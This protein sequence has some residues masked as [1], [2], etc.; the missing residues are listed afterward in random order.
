MQTHAP[1]HVKILP[2]QALQGQAD[3]ANKS[4]K[5]SAKET[6]SGTIDADGH[7]LRIGG[8]LIVWG[9]RS[10]RDLQGEY[11]TPQTELA[12]E[13]FERR[14]V[15]YQHGLDD[16]L[17]ANPIGV[18]DQLR[19][20][21]TGVWA[22]AQ[23]DLRHRYADAVRRLIER[24][25][26]GW[27]SGSL[28]HLVE[29]ARDGRIVRW[30]LVEGSLTP[31]PAEPRRTDVQT[32]KS[33]YEVLGLDT[34]RLALPGLEHRPLHPLMHSPHPVQLPLPRKGTRP[35]PNPY[36]DSFDLLEHTPVND[37]TGRKRLPFSSSGA[38]DTQPLPAVNGS[39]GQISVG[40][41]FDRL[42]AVDLLHGYMLLR[43][44]KSFHGVSEQYANALAYK[45]RKTGLSSAIKTNEL[46][47]TM[48]TGFGDEWV[49]ELWSA[50][51]WEKARQDNVVLP[52]FR[53]IEM[54]SSPFDLPVEGTDPSVYFV[55]ESSNESQL[56]LG[57]SGNPIPDS[58]IGSHKIQLTAKKLALRVG[59][60]AELV[61]DAILPVLNIYRVQAQRA[62][63]DSID[64]V[65]LNGDME[66]TEGA[67]IN[68]PLAP[69]G[70]ERF[71]AFNGLR[72]LPLVANSALRLDVEG[73]LTL[74]KLRETRFK[75]PARYAARPGDL[76]WIVDSGTYAQLLN[77]S[78][79]LTLDK[80]GALATAQTGQIG[81]I[82]G[83]PVFT[84][85]ELPMT[86]NTGV[87]ATT[88]NDKGT[89]LC[90]YR[91]GWFVGYRRRV[92]VNVDYL[93]YYDSYQL[94]ATVRLAFAP[95]DDYAASA[96]INIT[97]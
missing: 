45:V 57:G 21:E 37:T 2:M 97:I 58:K 79:F 69:G 36:N 92:A 30:P 15:L 55:P 41:S 48:Q 84:S 67:N 68:T 23:L 42:D 75:M 85:A 8:Y 82:D 65:L 13:W 35:M 72:R 46:M 49:P 59:F 34:D 51:I 81:F 31:T 26:L 29:V 25:L 53:T 70:N 77:L 66:D 90:V 12:L 87:V 76:A 86:D 71:L 60:S 1:Y 43:A 73:A 18:I 28:P 89:A 10:Q 74:A 33:A 50:Q 91:P 64:Y 56:V 6:A 32:I 38:G 20:D 9:N 24:G 3:H 39:S 54:P 17:K 62:I 11:F 88:G 61:E 4:S 40:S 44:A 78:E 95:F 7:G 14:P 94:T 96:A 22:E 19:A 93:P 47:H 83:I 16:H 52:L 27:S 63:A 80:A 5:F